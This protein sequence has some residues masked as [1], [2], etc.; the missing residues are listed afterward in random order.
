MPSVVY[1]DPLRR[2]TRMPH[3][4]TNHAIRDPSCATSRFTTGVADATSQTSNTPPRQVIPVRLS[5]QRDAPGA[6]PSLGD[7]PIPAVSRPLRHAYAPHPQFVPVAQ[8]RSEPILPGATGRFNPI[9]RTET[10]PFYSGPVGSLRLVEPFR[11][12]SWATGLPAGVALPLPSRSA[13]TV[14]TSRIPARHASSSLDPFDST[15]TCLAVIRFEPPRHAFPWPHRATG[16]FVPF[17]ST[18]HGDNP[19]PTHPH[20]CDVPP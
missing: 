3:V 11:R 10:G 15:A 14:H 13:V 17:S 12:P 18:T 20:H 16:Q 4:A 1:D 19:I 7:Q 8:R 5:T 2:A 9:R 6:M